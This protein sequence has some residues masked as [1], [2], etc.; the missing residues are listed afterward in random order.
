MLELK[1]F[2]TVYAVLVAI[3]SVA[4]IAVVWADH[5]KNNLKVFRETTTASRRSEVEF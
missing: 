5:R 2:L 4:T 1:A 3:V